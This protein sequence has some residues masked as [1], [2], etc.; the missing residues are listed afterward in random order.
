MELTPRQ[1]DI[2]CIVNL[3]KSAYGFKPRGSAFLDLQSMSDEDITRY[4]HELSAEADRRMEE[5][6]RIEAEAFHKL[7][8]HLNTM[9]GDYCIDRETAIRWEMEAHDTQDREHWLYCW[10]IG[11]EDMHHFGVRP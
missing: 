5:E 3:H 2:E 8:E 4:I 1:I 10:G 6:A 9:Q 11:F 7:E